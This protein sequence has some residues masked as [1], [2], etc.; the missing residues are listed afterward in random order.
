MIRSSVCLRFRRQS[1]LLPLL[2][3]F[4]S[5]CGPKPASTPTTSDPLGKQLQGNGQGPDVNPDAPVPA[6]S[7][8][9]GFTVGATCFKT[10]QA[11]CKAAACEPGEC[12]ELETM[13]VQV[14]CKK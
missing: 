3:A 4:A 1:P 6:D 2:L 5:A 7:P 11:A 12:L 13:P 8:D 14:Q 9:C 10:A